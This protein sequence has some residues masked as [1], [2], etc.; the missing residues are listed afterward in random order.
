M[1]ACSYL[2]R[3]LKPSSTSAVFFGSSIDVRANCGSA[4]FDEKRVKE[5]ALE[6]QTNLVGA[7]DAAV[8]LA[9]KIKAQNEKEREEKLM[10]DSKIMAAAHEADRQTETDRADRTL[11]KQIKS[12]KSSITADEKAALDEVNADKKVVRERTSH[13][14][15]FEKLKNQRNV[16][17]I[18][19][20]CREV[21]RF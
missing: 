2:S 4:F 1:P 16:S 21:S 3:Q 18:F 20:R 17:V 12:G 9:F 13:K 19:A 10:A 14:K 6:D 5:M 8:T 11:N 15:W 7:L